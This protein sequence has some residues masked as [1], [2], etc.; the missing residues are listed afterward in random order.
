MALIRPAVFKDAAAIAHVHI[1]AWRTTYRSL[2]PDDVLDNLSFE[3]RQE[4][5]KSILLWRN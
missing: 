4:R 2:M 3:R 1:D 5:R